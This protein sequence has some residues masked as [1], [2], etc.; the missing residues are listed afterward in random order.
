MILRLLPTL[1]ILAASPVAFS[2]DKPA[3]PAAAPEKRALAFHRPETKGSKYDLTS[4]ASQ[5][6]TSDIHMDDDVHPG[7]SESTD[8]TL[9]GT[10]EV[11]EVSPKAGNVTAYTLTV[12]K[13]TLTDG[14]G[15][16]DG[17]EPD[18]VIT[19]KVENFK[20]TWFAHGGEVKGNL[21]DG[22][23]LALPSYYGVDEPVDDTFAPKGP[24]AP[25]EKWD[26]EIAKFGDIIKK[27]DGIELDTAKSSV[28]ARYKGPA[29][30]AG[31]ESDVVV[32]SQTFVYAK[33]SGLP[34]GA[35]L[36]S[37]QSTHDITLSLP[38]DAKTLAVPDLRSVSDDQTRF[39]GKNEGKEYELD[40]K[41]HSER[42][43]SMKP[44]K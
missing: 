23:E 17:F 28:H 2:Q 41:G 26:P 16:D 12:K 30:V 37:S 8:V 29:T 39:S 38:R 20:T 7:G 43:L 44:A 18:T 40:Y 33:I 19:A 4:K 13:M 1:A 25:G 34:E 24:V 9:T 32:S 35:K 14:T 27:T 3:A 5:T 36:L 21:K 11:T 31:I 10:L 22:L 15:T 6:R 42:H